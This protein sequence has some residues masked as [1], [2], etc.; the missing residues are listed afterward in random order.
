M[1]LNQF[2]GSDKHLEETLLENRWRFMSV[3]LS[4]WQCMEISV[5][6]K[7]IHQKAIDE[8]I[9]E[10]ND[11][12]YILSVDLWTMWPTVVIGMEV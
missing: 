1:D 8:K 3:D 4:K 5:S 12:L 7:N 6:S 10:K 9:D 2:V 11:K